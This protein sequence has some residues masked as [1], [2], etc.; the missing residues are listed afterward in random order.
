VMYLF[1]SKLFNEKIISLF[2]FVTFIVLQNNINVNYLNF[3]F[4]LYKTGKNFDQ[5]SV[6]Y[7]FYH[8]V[9]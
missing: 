4:E 9:I 7:I 2:Q 8:L 5:V 1:L 3:T 6:R